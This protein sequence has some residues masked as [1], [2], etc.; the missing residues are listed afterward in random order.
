MRNTFQWVLEYFSDILSNKNV[1]AVKMSFQ[2]HMAIRNRW[3]SGCLLRRSRK[4]SSHALCS[5][6]LDSQI[7]AISAPQIWLADWMCFVVITAWR[8]AACPSTVE[9]GG[10]WHKGEN[11]RA[12]H[13]VWLRLEKMLG[14]MS[15][16]NSP[17]RALPLS[18]SA[19]SQQ[20]QGC[21]SWA[22]SW[23]PKKANRA[24]RKHCPPPAVSPALPKHLSLHWAMTNL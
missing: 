12:M 4:L 15:L 2:G 6:H 3:I 16:Y 10:R 8:F 11:R 21:G 1:M 5:A 23:K 18:H 20:E 17:E 9:L 7:F 14:F 19:V 24:T 22:D 13:L